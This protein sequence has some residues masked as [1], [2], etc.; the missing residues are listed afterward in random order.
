MA[1]NHSEI[2]FNKKRLKTPVEQTPFT[3]KRIFYILAEVNI[4]EQGENSSEM[5]SLYTKRV[6]KASR[7]LT[8]KILHNDF[9]PFE[10]LVN[11][12]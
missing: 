9:R 10:F 5:V 11:R 8:K 7:T 6:N 1:Y 3:A 12:N 2:L 4:V